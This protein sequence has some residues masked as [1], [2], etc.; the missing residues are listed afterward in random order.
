MKISAKV[1]LAGTGTG[2]KGDIWFKKRVMGEMAIFNLK[3]NMYLF[4]LVMPDLQNIQE[5]VKV[6]C[7]NVTYVL[8]AGVAEFLEWID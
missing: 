7:R 4:N 5:F 3:K 2:F 1:N 8:K 6:M